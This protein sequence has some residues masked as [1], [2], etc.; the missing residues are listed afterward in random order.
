MIKVKATLNSAVEFVKSN[1]RSSH[2]LPLLNELLLNLLQ[3]S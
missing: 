3:L 1:A 2:L